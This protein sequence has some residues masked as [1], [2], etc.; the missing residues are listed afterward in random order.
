[1]KRFTQIRLLYLLLIITFLSAC[2]ATPKLKFDEQVQWQNQAIAS[3]RSGDFL[4]AESALRQLLKTNEKDAQSW[5]LLGNV[6][7]RE[8]RIEAA[9]NAYQR[10]LSYQPDL[11]AARH[12]LALTHLRLA[13]LTLIEGQAYDSEAHL[14][15]AQALLRLQGQNRAAL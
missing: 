3:Y 7:L 15:L 13:T 12:N 9:L 11:A 14:N 1:M 10:A 8:Q 2:S 6:H 4:G 5:L